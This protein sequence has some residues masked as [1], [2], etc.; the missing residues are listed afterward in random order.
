MNENSTTAS[1]LVGQALALLGGLAGFLGNA[2]LIFF[3]F[4]ARLVWTSVVLFFASLPYVAL[5]VFTAI[6]YAMKEVTG[7]RR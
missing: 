7:K 3:S 5:F 6:R 4:L 1:A 2:L